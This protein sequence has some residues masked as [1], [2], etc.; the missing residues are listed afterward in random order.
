MRGLRRDKRLIYYSNPVGTS[1]ILDNNGD[2]TFE[3]KV[4]YSTKIPIKVNVSVGKGSFRDL[5]SGRQGEFDATIIIYGQHEIT[6]DTLLWIDDLENNSS[7]YRVVSVE[8]RSK[9]SKIHI[10]KVSTSDI[11]FEEI[12]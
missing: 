10:H 6:K 7:D 12:E 5:I 4:V 1:D 11:E 9:P 2:K 3:K 8:P